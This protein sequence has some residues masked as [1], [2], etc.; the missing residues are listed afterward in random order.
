M[1]RIC[2]SFNRASNASLKSFFDSLD[3]NGS[4]CE[5]GYDYVIKCHDCDLVL[6][7][8]GDAHYQIETYYDLTDFGATCEGEI[9]IESCACGEYSNFRIN[10]TCD[11]EWNY[12]AYEYS[13]YETLFGDKDVS[14]YETH[15]CAVTDPKCGFRYTTIHYYEQDPTYPCVVVRY[16]AVYLGHSV[17]KLGDAK[18]IIIMANDKDVSLD[19]KED[20]IK[21]NIAEEIISNAISAAIHDSRFQPITE[22]ELKRKQDDVQK[23]TDKYIAKVEEAIKEKEKQI[24]EF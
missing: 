23:L 19:V 12:D 11:F 17:T 18:E 3:L 2:F 21:E 7:G 9:V 22:D 5:D 14:Y 24:M 10:G 4:S 8:Y 20:E 15:V 6:E 13:D 16:T 1:W